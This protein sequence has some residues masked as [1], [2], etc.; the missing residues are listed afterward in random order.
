[1]WY[2]ILMTQIWSLLTSC[3]LFLRDRE[4]PAYNGG[5]FTLTLPENYTVFDID[6]IGVWCE[7]LSQD[8]GYLAIMDEDRANVPPF[9]EESPQV[10]STHI[11]A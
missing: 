11:A 4:L 9:I 2:I 3:L 6:F 7:T 10:S 8:F 5:T 1:M